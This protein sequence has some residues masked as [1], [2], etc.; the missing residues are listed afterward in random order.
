MKQTRT[1]KGIYMLDCQDEMKKKKLTLLYVPDQETRE[2]LQRK[3]CQIIMEHE[4]KSKV[5]VLS[6]AE[7]QQLCDLGIHMHFI[8]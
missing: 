5:H 7:Y 3:D 8:I 6:D 1:A 4:L 2:M